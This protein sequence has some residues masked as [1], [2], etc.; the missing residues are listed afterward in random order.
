MT[1][2]YIRTLVRMPGWVQTG[3]DCLRRRRACCS[4]SRSQRSA[5]LYSIVLFLGILIII[6]VPL[7]DFVKDCATDFPFSFASPTEVCKC[8]RKTSLA[9]SG[10]QCGALSNFLG[11]AI[12]SVFFLIL[13]RARSF[14]GPPPS[15]HGKGGC[16]NVGEKASKCGIICDAPACVP[17]FLPAAVD[18]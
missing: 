13:T 16:K 3:Q 6:R 7:D 4:H 5:S 11:V 1:D 9:K 12:A 14:V 15:G 18:F 8:Y 2:I 10:A 17:L